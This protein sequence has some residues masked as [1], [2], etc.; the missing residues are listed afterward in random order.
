MREALIFL[1]LGFIFGITCPAGAVRIYQWTDENGVVHA[2]D[3]PENVPPEYRRSADVIDTES[4]D[5][6]T[7]AK[8]IL[9][10]VKSNRPA[11]YSVAGV[12]VLIFFLRMLHGYIKTTRKKSDKEKYMNA[13][14]L[15][16]VERMDSIE[17]RRYMMGLLKH[18][19]YTIVIPGES[20]NPVVDFIAEKEELKYAVHVYNQNGNITRVIV[21]DI[22]REKARFDC[23]RSMI[24]TRQYC[25]NDAR[26]LGGTAGC[27]LVDKNALARWIY[28]FHKES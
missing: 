9:T 22:E 27:A 19:G 18:R 26:E 21:N 14:G 23:N 5:L 8:D 20:M 15:S 16:G 1:I 25:D 10:K 17:L 28:E 11:I 2:V 6:E 7:R 4:A 24:I 13:Y 12:L 3:D